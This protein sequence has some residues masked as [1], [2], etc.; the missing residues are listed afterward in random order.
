[1]GLQYWIWIAV[2]LSF[3]LYIG[4]AIWSRAGSTKEFYV[5]GGGVHPIANWYGNCS[6]LDVSRLVYFHGGY[7]IV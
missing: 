5:A 7:Y 3:S 4:I 6:R 2:G 1:M